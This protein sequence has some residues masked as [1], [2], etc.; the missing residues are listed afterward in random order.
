MGMGALIWTE[1]LQT[2]RREGEEASICREASTVEMK[3][4]SGFLL[5]LP[6]FS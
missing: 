3:A 5:A 1:L 6:V 4:A 2:G